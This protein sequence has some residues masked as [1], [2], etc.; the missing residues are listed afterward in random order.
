VQALILVGGEGTRLRPLTTVQPKP[1]VPLVNQPFM[2]YM[3]EWLG[4]HGV[5]DV[6]MSCGYLPDGIKSVLGDGSALGI[7]LRYIE[8]PTPLG[9][10]GALKY[11][12]GV[13]DERFLMLNGDVLTDF[14]I[15]AQ[16]RQHERTGARGTLALVAVEDPSAYGLVRLNHDRS[17]N[18]FLEKPRPEEIDTNLVNAGIYVL[19]RDVLDEMAPAGS[20]ISIERDLFPT[21]VGHGLY[22]YEASG[23]WMDIGTPGRYLQATREI[24]D[25]HVHTLIGD[26]VHAAG[27]KLVGDGRIDGEVTAPSLVAAGCEID[28]GARVGPHSVL[29]RGV[30]VAAGSEVTASVVFDGAS[31]GSGTVVRDSVIGRDVEVGPGCVI[32]GGVILGDGV[33]LGAD[34]V[35]RAGARIFPGVE[36]PAGA[37]QI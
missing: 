8:E 5:D 36:L 16:L 24:L 25:R 26:R 21:L 7:R 32:E 15:T 19:H 29:G 18:G 6:I 35:V 12:E 22:G 27:G 9:T 11:A 28:A 3:L 30:R 34:N 33:R 4:G 20:T 31:V 13:L 2:A 10:G 1:V 23:Y 14:D 17:V 37:I